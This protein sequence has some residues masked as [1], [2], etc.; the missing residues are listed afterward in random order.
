MA[1][2]TIKTRLVVKMTNEPILNAKFIFEDDGNIMLM[3]CIY[4]DN[5]VIAYC[6]F[7]IALEPKHKAKDGKLL[8]GVDS[9]VFTCDAPL[10]KKHTVSVGHIC[11]KN[12]DS[13]D[14]CEH[15]FYE[16]NI[17]EVLFEDDAEE[18]RRAL[19]AEIRRSVMKA[20]DA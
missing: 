16:Q 15:H 20:V 14:Y 11:G 2:W 17:Y 10:C 7:A 6:D 13:I 5:K 1:A 3:N 12:G 9:K 18:K 19:H 4:C 8:A